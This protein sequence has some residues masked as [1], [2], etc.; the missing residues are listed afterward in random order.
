MLC[1]FPVLLNRAPTLH[2]LGFQA[3]QPKLICGRA[4]QI[5]PLVCSGFNADFDGDQIAVHVPLSPKARFEAWRLISPGSHFFSPATRR[6][7]FL[8]NQ[9][10]VLGIYYFTI[11]NSVFS[12][13]NFV[14][15]YISIDVKFISSKRKKKTFFLFS[16]KE[17]IL[18]TVEKKRLKFHQSIWLC[19]QKP[20][21]FDCEQEL[22]L[23][24]RRLNQK[25]EEEKHSLWHWIINKPKVR[26]FQIT[27]GRLI[28]SLSFA[29]LQRK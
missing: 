11:R 25:G 26:I 18:Q 24:E 19:D 13:S 10:I 9:D 20:N 17:E 29:Q 6:P 12:F 27:L 8:P 7:T 5:H 15:R 3:F 2:R 28:F 16:K 22:L 4:I 21:F 23:R 14:S 1:G